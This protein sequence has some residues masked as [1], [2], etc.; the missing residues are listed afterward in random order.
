MSKEKM[1][2][3]IKF[4]KECVN[5][6][7]HFKKEAFSAILMGLVIKDCGSSAIKET[8]IHKTTE[9]QVKGMSVKE[10]LLSKKPKSHIEK[11][12][13][14]GF[15]EEVHNNKKYW[16]SKDIAENFREA[17]EPLPKNISDQI[18]KCRIKGWVMEHGR[19]YRL[20]NTGEANVKE[21]FSKGKDK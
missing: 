12:L 11:T 3:F 6:E 16:T 13:C 4:A 1:I 8:M 20:T 9:P 10:F 17:R 2:E 18:S 14:F 5:D 15:F 21:G 7:E 19:G